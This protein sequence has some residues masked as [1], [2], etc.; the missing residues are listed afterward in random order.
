MIE[1]R[2]KRNTVFSLTVFTVISSFGCLY[3]MR[4]V[5]AEPQGTWRYVALV[6]LLIVTSIMVYKLL[7]NYKIIKISH[8]NVFV[9]YPFR[10]YRS[11][12][13]IKELGAWQETVVKTN[14]SEF[15]QL[16]LVFTNK[17]Y[18]KLSNQENSEYDKVYKYIKKKAPKK[19][20][21]D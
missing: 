1:S 8:D 14:K 18:I 9:Y 3:F 21:K 15:K 16:K 2:P 17:G 13:P 5:L 19:E 20:V 11:T 4:Q 10:L 12:T 7:F 6:F